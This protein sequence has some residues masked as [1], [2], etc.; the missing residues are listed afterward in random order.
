MLGVIAGTA[1]GAIAP[2][3]MRV[4]DA[5]LRLL[6]GVAGDTFDASHPHLPECL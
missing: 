6:L 2:N 4:A 5:H 1:T 3:V